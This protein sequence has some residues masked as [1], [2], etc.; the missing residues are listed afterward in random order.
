VTSYFNLLVHSVALILTMTSFT[1]IFN[2]KRRSGM[3]ESGVHT[4][5]KVQ[6]QHV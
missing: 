5:N 2:Y 4:Q 6:V 3:V 1:G